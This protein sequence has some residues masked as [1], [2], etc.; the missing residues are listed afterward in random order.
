MLIGIISFGMNL[1]RI[2]NAQRLFESLKDFPKLIIAQ[3]Y[4]PEKTNNNDIIH[5][6]K[7]PLGIPLAR[8]TLEVAFLN[9]NHNHIIL[10]DD[11][12]EILEIHKDFVLTDFS[13]QGISLDNVQLSRNAIQKCPFDFW[14]VPNEDIMYY[15]CLKRFFGEPKKQLLLKIKHNTTNSTWRVI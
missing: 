14:R 8:K 3:G 13:A 4:K 12:A 9:T 7:T 15:Y 10:L 6:F 5:Y 1:T 11:D 2:Q